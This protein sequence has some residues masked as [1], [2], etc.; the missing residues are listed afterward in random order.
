MKRRG[1]KDSSLHL[2]GE[3]LHT[4][5]ARWKLDLEKCTREQLTS[6]LDK[7]VAEYKPRSYALYVTLIRKSLKFLD[8]NDL[9]EAVVLPMKV[10]RTKTVSKQ[11]LTPDEV[12]KLIEKAPTLEDRLLIELLDELGPRRAELAWVRIKDIQFDEHGAVL[13]LTGKTGTRKRR[14]YNSVPDLRRHINDNPKRKDPNAYLFFDGSKWNDVTLYRHVVSLG[15]SI[16]GKEIHP[17][18]FRHTKATSDSKYFTDR[19]M[20]MLYGWSRPDMVGVYSHLSMKDVEDKDLVL[21]GLKSK[22]EIL[23]PIVQAQMCGVCGEANAPIAMYCQKCGKVLGQTAEIGDLEKLID[24][25][26]QEAL[27]KKR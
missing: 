25:R 23:K 17:H 3:V 7:M 16:L 24:E 2:Y 6:T 9:R 21:H 15:K 18:Q 8:R 20:M 10:D 11:I 13:T 14:V 5:K 26:V 4:I 19:E 22:E 1:V 12:R 27:L